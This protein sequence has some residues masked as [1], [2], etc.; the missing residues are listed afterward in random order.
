MRAVH[1]FALSATLLDAHLIGCGSMSPRRPARV[2][3]LLLLFTGALGGCSGC[4]SKPA[5]S[6]GDTSP[7]APGTKASPTPE[8]FVYGKVE[9]EHRLEG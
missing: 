5:A 1:R 4:G 2:L 6:T 9:G 7:P 8:I 3:V